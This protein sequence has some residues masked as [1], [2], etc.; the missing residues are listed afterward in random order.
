MLHSGAPITEF[1]P[2]MADGYIQR[3]EFKEIEALI[4][5]SVEKLLL[6]SQM[7]RMGTSNMDNVA[8]DELKLSSKKTDT[9]ANNFNELGENLQSLDCPLNIAFSENSLNNIEQ[10]DARMDLADYCFE[11]LGA[12]SICFL[13]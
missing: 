12:A 13:K 10:I 2:V 7:A 11:K 8:Q 1:Q 9:P 3:T 5:F 6:D 4:D